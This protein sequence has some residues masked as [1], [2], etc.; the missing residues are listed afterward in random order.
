[1]VDRSQPGEH[2]LGNKRLTITFN[3]GQSGLSH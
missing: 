1:M 2:H 3:N